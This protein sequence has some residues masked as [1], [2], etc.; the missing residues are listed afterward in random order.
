MSAR[1]VTSA[2]RAAGHRAIV[3]A[4]AMGLAATGTV[5]TATQAQ[6]VNPTV[7]PVVKHP[8]L[9]VGSPSKATSSKRPTLQLGSTGEAVSDLQRR[10]PMPSVTGYF[11]TM[12]D[13][14]V[15]A[16]QKKAKLKQN[17]I[18]GKKTWKKVGKIRVTVAA[19]PAAAA[20]P[21]PVASDSLRSRI[22]K[23]AASYQGVPYVATGYT[24]EQGF[25]CSSYTQWVYQQAGIDLGGAYTVTQY[26]RA[27]KI[28]K[29]QAM[30]GD[31]VF[32]YNYPN[33]FLGHMGI[34]AGNGKMWHAPRTGRVVSLDAVYS[35]KVLYARVL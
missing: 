29:E 20:K 21:A 26:A 32:F 8:D 19:A 30:P 31:L 3:A 5:A 23:I 27:Q 25:N 22:M 33:N 13:A 35:E 12:T 2:K 34:Y 4:V 17:G 6:A 10:L 16:L 7:Y 28:T 1:R 11:G 18:V 9:H 14:Y 15:R 24:P